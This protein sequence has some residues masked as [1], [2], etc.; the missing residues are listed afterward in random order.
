MNAVP[1]P[2]L[3][4]RAFDNNGN[5]LVGGLL[6][7]Y[8][9]GTS[10]PQASYPSSS[11]LV[12]N[13]NPIVLNF[14]G[15]CALWLDPTLSYKIN[16]T[17]SL[18][19]TIPGYPVDNVAGF[20]VLLSQNLTQSMVGIA[21]YPQTAAELAANVTPTS[22]NYPPYNLLRYGADPTGVLSSDA[23]MT[24]AIS[25]CGTTGGTIRVPNG[26]YLFA[27]QI[28]LN[29]KTS[30]ILQGDGGVSGGGQTA[31]QMKY[32]GTASPWINM[33]SSVGVEIRDIQLFHTSTSFTGTYIKCG[34]DGTHS[35]PAWCAVRRCFFG[36]SQN[37]VGNIHLD[38]DKCQQFTAEGCNFADGNPSL[39]LAASGSYCNALR[40]RDNQFV[41]SYNTPIQGGG[42]GVDIRGNVF[43]GCGA[44][45][46]TPAGAISSQSGA[47]LLG[48]IFEANWLGDA[49]TATG[50]W[51]DIYV[52]GG[53]IAGNYISGNVTA[54]SGITL[55]A[56]FGVSIEN[57]I[58][59]TLLN[60]IQFA[61]GG[62]DLVV[63][64]NV[65]NTVTNPWVN[66][67]QIATGAF[68]F[69]SN[70][71]FG[72]PGTNHGL[73]ATN[74]YQVDCDGI[75]RQWGLATSQSHGSNTVTF[76][77]AFPNNCFN[78]TATL[79]GVAAGTATIYTSSLTQTNFAATITDGT[80]TTDSFYWF[81]IGN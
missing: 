37:G 66:G 75:V 70:F 72:I 3:I 73:Q 25:V 58:F 29:V 39:S 8:A 18:G 59:S 54:T 12:P 15:E 10:T 22:Y 13:T 7:T 20:G 28:A 74:G 68:D 14:R 27:S 65:A 6:Y 78:V 34:N 63:K 64:G 42:E 32:S 31:T 11:E 2:T 57:N 38:L 46:N 51:I 79:S 19:N 60:G 23:A 76:P 80:S 62:N 71:G 41:N 21:L 5:P 33:Q 69:G 4:F 35:D 56:A 81:A 55:R 9:A 67:N 61:S 26:S 43:E 30:I 53:K 77:L 49:G 40:V 17:D 36:A 50:T 47:A 48:L 24:S 16:L 44:V 52:E 1:S 45:A